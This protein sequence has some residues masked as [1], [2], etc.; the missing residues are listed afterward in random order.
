MAHVKKS[1]KDILF[2]FA[3]ALTVS[4]ILTF[5]IFYIQKVGQ[6]HGVTIFAVKPFDGK[7]QNLKTSFFTFLIFAEV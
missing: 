7:C 2:I 4:G 5:Q 1:T 3:L 6:G